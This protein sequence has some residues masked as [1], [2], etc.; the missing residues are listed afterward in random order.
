M[1]YIGVDACRKGWFAVSIDSDQ[2]WKTDIFESIGEL[3]RTYQCN[4]L[5]LIDIPIGM[6][7]ND[8]R[9]CDVEARKLLRMR[10]SSVFPAPC[11][12]A[13][14]ADSYKEACRIN[15]KS[16]G[17]KLSVQTWNIVGKIREVDDLLSV[18]KKTRHCL[19]ESHPEICFWA[20]AGQQPMAFYK[21]T[22]QGFTER[23]RLLKK[24]FPPTQKIVGA[25]MQK[26]LRKDLA[27]DDILDA[28]ALAVTAVSGR[29]L[30]VTI[31]EHPPRD[32]MG[33][34]MEV[35]FATKS[36]R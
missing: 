28:L 29:K 2:A 34:P 36:A 21:K 5:I 32:A 22:E 16:L 30:I 13:I 27:R 14:H 3:W 4:D 6:P 31:P 12:R 17:T 23:L 15:Q 7:E 18:N 9:Q 1:K 25:A 20:L 19:R 8:K 11:R 35:V 33:L 26:F 24:S 10:A